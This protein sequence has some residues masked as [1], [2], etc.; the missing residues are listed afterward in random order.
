MPA[1][2]PWSSACL[3]S[4]AETCEDEIRSS[5]IGSA[6]V[7]RRFA[8]SCAEP[9]VKPPEI[10][11]PCRPSMPSGFW[12]KS[13]YGAEIDLAVEHDREVLERGLRVAAEELAL[14]ALGDLARRLLPGLA[15]RVA[16]LEG[17]VRRARAARAVVE[18][19]L[20][21]LDVLAAQRGVV[22]QDV[23]GVGR[24]RLGRGLLGA[25]DDR[26]LRHRRRPGRCRRS[27]GACRGSSVQRGPVLLRAGAGPSSP[28][29]RRRT[30]SPC[31]L[32]AVVGGLAALGALDGVV[33]RQAGGGGAGRRAA[34]DV[35]VGRR[36]LAARPEHVLLPV[37]EEELRGRADLLARLVGVVGRRERDV[38]LVLARALDLGLGDAELVDA[39]AHD[40]DR[41]VDR[42]ARDLGLLGG[43]GL[44]GRARRRP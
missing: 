26:A 3:P 20:G 19:L 4:V 39:L 36:R 22:A 18:V 25:H 41:A 21:V 7:F 37:V 11:E 31:R 8:S 32:V 13:M 35:R 23:E 33:L 30:G 15:P 24:R 17:D 34:G 42:V 28:G 16:E 14:A 27:G 38:D 5:L 40:V 12:L 44:V 10:S 29:R 9:I 43:L 1:M 2:R 6:P